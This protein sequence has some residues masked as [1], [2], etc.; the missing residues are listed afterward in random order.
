M[1]SRALFATGITVWKNPSHFQNTSILR[2][3]FG[4]A[5]ALAGMA[6]VILAISSSFN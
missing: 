2:G 5:T 3:C 1:I 6:S 4:S